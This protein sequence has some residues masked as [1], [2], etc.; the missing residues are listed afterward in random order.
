[1]LEEAAGDLPAGIRLLTVLDGQRQEI[2]ALDRRLGGDD[3]GEHH[4]AATADHRRAVRLLGDLA[5]L[6]R[7]DGAV[8]LHFDR[9]T[10]RGIR[11]PTLGDTRLR[12][13]RRRRARWVEMWSGSPVTD[14]FRASRSGFGTARYPSSGDTRGGPGACR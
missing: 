2:P 4:R 13:A 3:G 12:G 11:P 9:V 14:G 8:D 10:H 7:Q 5:G 6:D 1:A